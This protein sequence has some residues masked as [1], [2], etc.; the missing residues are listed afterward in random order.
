MKCGLPMKWNVFPG[1]FDGF[2][3]FG[4]SLYHLFQNSR[5]QNDRPLHPGHIR[6]ASHVPTIENN[7]PS[8]H[9]KLEQILHQ[10]R[11]FPEK[12]HAV[13]QKIRLNNNPHRGET[14]LICFGK[15][16]TGIPQASSHHS[17]LWS[18]PLAKGRQEELCARRQRQYHLIYPSTG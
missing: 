10:N 16:L 17:I 6:P 1:R 7:N 5:I 8:L 3:S 2:S 13:S 12:G 15:L 18:P 14:F 11:P 4:L 9:S